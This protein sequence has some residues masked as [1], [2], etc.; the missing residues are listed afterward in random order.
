[1][2]TLANAI[3]EEMNTKG[4]KVAVYWKKIERVISLRER[5]FC[6]SAGSVRMKDAGARTLVKARGP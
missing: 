3:A 2:R 5:I 6:A 4:V 1:M